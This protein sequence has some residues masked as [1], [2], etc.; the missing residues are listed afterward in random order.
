MGMTAMRKAG[1]HNFPAIDRVVYGK[2]A[3]DALNDEAVR[4][5]AKR[6][7]LIV[8]HTLNTRTDEIEKIRRALGNLKSAMFVLD[9]ARDGG[10]HLTSVSVSGGGH[11]HGVGMCQ[12]G[13]VGMAGAGRSYVEI[14]RQYYSGAHLRKLY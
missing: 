5:D 4:L 10:G 6:V 1:I 9:L 7:F 13:S 2:A 8:S 12:V 11:G 14:L 3:S